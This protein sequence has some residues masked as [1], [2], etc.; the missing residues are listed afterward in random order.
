MC[1]RIDQKSSSPE[2]HYLDG[3]CK[4]QMMILS[5]SCIIELNTWRNIIVNVYG[6]RDGL[7]IK[8]DN[9]QKREL[10]NNENES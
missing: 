5:Y 6:E 3:P 10:S 8:I 1:F 2:I 9:S 4:K 7:N